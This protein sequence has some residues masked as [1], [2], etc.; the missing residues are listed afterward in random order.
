MDRHRRHFHAAPGMHMKN[1]MAEADASLYDLLSWYTSDACKTHDIHSGWK[2]AALEF[3]V[4]KDVTRSTFIAI[5]SMRNSFDV[6]MK[7]ARPWLDKE[8]RNCLAFEDWAVHS[9][10]LDEFGDLQL[11]YQDVQLEVV[12]KFRGQPD[13]KDRVEVMLVR[14]WQFRKFS[15]SRWA[16][17]GR[18][19]RALLS[20][21]VAGSGSFHRF[22]MRETS[23]SKF[24]IKGFSQWAGEV[25]RFAIMATSS[26]VVDAALHAL[27]KDDQLMQV[28][29]TVEAGIPEDL[30]RQQDIADEVWETIADSIDE[31]LPFSL[32]VGDVVANLGSL[33]QGGMP[34]EETSAKICPLFRIGFDMGAIEDGLALLA[35]VSFSST[36][37]EQGRAAASAIM[38]N[39]KDYCANAMTFP[40]LVKQAAALVS[41]TRAAKL[42]PR[43]RAQLGGLRRRRPNRI[44]G[45]RV[46]V[47]ELS[48]QAQSGPDGCAS[49]ARPTKAIIKGH[50]RAWRAKSAQVKQ[51]YARKASW[52]RVESAT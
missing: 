26:T 47:E 38:K 35:N 17:L 44:S 5:A 27:L 46:C 37:V 14:L 51:H 45:R 1:T 22:T 8:L 11:R 43:L 4:T 40:N 24:F 48:L 32:C 15:D 49:G 25:R 42:P 20:A 36:T 10:W 30:C 33:S 52:A 12:A 2:A 6:L 29:G 31:P 23:S 34:N 7:Q 28:I 21:V 16:N 18:S 3:L 50:G 13:V 41:S 9:K 19:W 39:H